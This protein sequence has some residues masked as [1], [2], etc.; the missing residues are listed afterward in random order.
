LPYISIP[1]SITSIGKDAFYGCLLLKHIVVDNSEPAKCEQNSFD[2]RNTYGS[3]LFVPVGSIPV[4][5]AA[6][7]WRNFYNIREK[8]AQ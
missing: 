1:A 7:G 6:Q 2:Y 4:Y 8:T 3:T 5:K